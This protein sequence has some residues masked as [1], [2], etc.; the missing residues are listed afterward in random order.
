MVSRVFRERELRQIV[1]ALEAFSDAISVLSQEREGAAAE[2]RERFD[3][4]LGRIQTLKGLAEVGH[5]LIDTMLT[6]KSIDVSPLSSYG[7]KK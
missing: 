1:S 6:G 4:A 2:E 7:G 5:R 3:F